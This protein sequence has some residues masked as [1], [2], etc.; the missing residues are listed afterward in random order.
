MGQRIML[1]LRHTR[2]LSEQEE[3]PGREFLWETRA[4]KSGHVC[5][6]I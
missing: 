4:F 6:G 3:K 1:G 2:D 5:W